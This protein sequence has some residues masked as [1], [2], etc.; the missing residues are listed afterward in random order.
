MADSGTGMDSTL[1]G[2][3]AK[4]ITPDIFGT[5]GN[6]S[7]HNMATNAFFHH[8]NSAGRTVAKM[9]GVGCWMAT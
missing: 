3:S 5:T 7:Q 4:L 6:I 2:L 9:A 8:R 1:S